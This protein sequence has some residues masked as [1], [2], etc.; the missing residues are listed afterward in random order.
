MNTDHFIMAGTALGAALALWAWKMQRDTVPVVDYEEPSQEPDFIDTLMLAATPS[1]WASSTT[2][3]ETEA[4]NVRAFLDMLAYAE[5]TDGPRGYQTMFGYRYFNDYADHPRI[6]WPYTDQAGR[7]IKTSA[8]GRYQIIVSTW[9]SLKNKLGL[10]DFSPA[11]QD[12][13]AIELIRQRG[14]LPDVKAGNVVDAIDKCRKTWASLPGAGYNQPERDI[15]ALKTAFN[16][17]G[18]T[19]QA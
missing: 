17:A 4:A 3:T 13:A 10:P 2:A 1:T 11:S 7:Q 9:D 16:N 14:A 12:A 5:G 18:G 6:Y 19:A 8:A 15:S